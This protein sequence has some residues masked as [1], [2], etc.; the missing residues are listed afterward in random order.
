VSNPTLAEVLATG[1]N[2]ANHQIVNLNSLVFSIN[3][4]SIF[5]TDIDTPTLLLHVLPNS[6]LAAQGPLSLPDGVCFVSVNDTETEN[7]S[8]EFRASQYQW[9]D[10]S[11]NEPILYASTSDIGRP[12][13]AVCGA[14][15]DGTSNFLVIGPTNLDGGSILTDGA[16]NVTMDGTLAFIMGGSITLDSGSVSLTGGTLTTLTL[17]VDGEATFSQQIF[18]NPLEVPTGSTQPAGLTA[19][20]IWFCTSAAARAICGAT[21]GI[22]CVATS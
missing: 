22:L 16:G 3:T 8:L 9:S 14:G 6:N 21:S 15:D 11:E 2:A 1:N 18:T 12:Y 13:V 4:V 19:G 20:Q 5:T 17:Q 10:P 7:L